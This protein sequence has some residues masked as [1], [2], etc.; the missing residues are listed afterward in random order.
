MRKFL[1]TVKVL[2]FEFCLLR[3]IL[4]TAFVCGKKTPPHMCVYADNSAF[5]IRA[6]VNEVN[7]W[8]VLFFPQA[9]FSPGKHASAMMKITMFSCGAMSA[10]GSTEKGII[11]IEFSSTEPKKEKTRRLGD[12]ARNFYEEKWGYGVVQTKLNSSRPTVACV[13]IVKNEIS[14]RDG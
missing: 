1:I 4:I 3:G 11:Q 10:R 7:L 9:D 13:S 8:K 5:S 12:R 2:R 14:T 6:N